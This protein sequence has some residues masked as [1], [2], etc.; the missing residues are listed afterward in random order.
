M[1][2]VSNSRQVFRRAAARWNGA[3]A[4]SVAA[5]QKVNGLAVE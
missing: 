4:N 2:S 1:A 5:L 3:Q